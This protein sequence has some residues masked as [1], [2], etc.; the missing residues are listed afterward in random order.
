MA[1]MVQIDCYGYRSTSANY[2]HTVKPVREA[3]RDGT[4]W[5]LTF[6]GWP[7]RPIHRIMTASAPGIDNFLVDWAF[8]EWEQRNNLNYRPINEPLAIPEND[9]PDTE[10][11]SV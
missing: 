9:L 11:A 1:K 5:Y 4:I 8:G 2:Q 7:R 3:Y 10:T 6:D